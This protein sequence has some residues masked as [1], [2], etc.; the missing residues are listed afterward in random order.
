MSTALVPLTCDKCAHVQCCSVFCVDLTEEEIKADVYE[1]NP[2]F[3][4]YLA[5]RADGSCVYLDKNR[6][7]S[8]YHSKPKVCN[9]WHCTIDDRW[10][11]L[12]E[13][14]KQQ[15]IEWKVLGD[16]EFSKKY[17][18]KEDKPVDPIGAEVQ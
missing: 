5:S 1:T 15:N 6:R 3:P 17:G 7:C 18:I 2:F 16:E 11:G 12:S 10:L 4:R 9:E 13:E 8:I 14:T